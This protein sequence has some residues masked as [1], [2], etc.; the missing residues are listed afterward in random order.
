MVEGKTHVDP[1]VAGKLFSKLVQHP[2]VVDTSIT[3]SPSEREREVLSLLAQG[4]NNADIGARLYLTEG[5]MR[6]YASAIFSKLG[7]SDSTQATVL[8]LR[9]RLVDSKE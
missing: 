4:L 9:H 5:T 2:A 8:A 7:V 6:N 3:D 1:A